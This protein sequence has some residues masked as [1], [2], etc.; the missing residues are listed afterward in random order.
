VAFPTFLAGELPDA[1]KFTELLKFIPHTVKK[2]VDEILTNNTLQDDDHLLFAADANSTYWFEIDVVFNSGA[3]PGF[4]FNIATPAG[5]SGS[6]TGWAHTTGN[7]LQSFTNVANATIAI[8]GIGGDA[9]LRLSG[10]LTIVTAGSV[11]FRWSQA[12]TNAS[13]TIVRKASK[14]LYGK[15]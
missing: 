7:V 6:F 1:D 8:A 3:T 2:P 13:N 10:D 11:K 14:L 5:G 4:Q 12:T 9:Y 15:S